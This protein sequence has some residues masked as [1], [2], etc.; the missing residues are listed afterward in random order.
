MG[1]I[2]YKLIAFKRAF[3]N[4]DC[5]QGLICIDE[6]E[7]SLHPVTQTR[8]FDFLLKWCKQNKIQIIIT[9]H[10]LYLIYH[11]LSLQQSDNYEEDSIS[12]TNI[13]TMQVGSD[14]N[15]NFIP[16]PDY[17]TIYRELTYVN[18]EETPP[19]KVNII[20]EDEEAKRLIKKILGTKIS[21][22]IEVITNISGTNGIPCTGLISLAKNGYRLLDDSIIILDADVSESSYS[23]LSF[24][25]I[26]KLYD[27]NNYCIE[28]AVV[29][30]ILNR[31]GSEPLFS[32]IE[33]SAVKAQFS[34]CGIDPNNINS[35]SIDKYKNWHNSHK[36]F[37][38]KA[39]SAFIRDN[40]D[41]FDEWKRIIVKMINK[42]RANKGLSPIE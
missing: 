17:K 27:P 9:T 20:C 30:Y 1:S 12:I 5:L 40:K 35:Q 36:S 19:Y 3:T 11:C 31:D 32:E 33:L 37:Y 10:S 24:K 34:D 4:E 29:N 41:K 42:R 23:R 25:Y 39:L 28:R 22:K 13:S 18:P 26:T 15:Y 16:N 21:R 8:F 14:H 7:A 38:L 2:L 6:F